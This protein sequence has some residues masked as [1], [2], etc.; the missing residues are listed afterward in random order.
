MPRLRVEFC[1]LGGGR[2][3][4][5]G[6]VDLPAGEPLASVTLDVT[7]TATPA[8][9]RPAVPAG[10]GTV[11][12]RLLAVDSAVYVDIAASPDPTTEPR[13]LL[14]PG[15]PYDLH[16]LPGQAVA[17]I[18]AADVPVHGDSAAI[19]PTDRSGTVGTGGAAQ[20][21]CPANA[22]RRFLLVANPDET[23]AFWFSTAGAAA[24]GAGSIQV[25]PGGAF[26]FDKV[27]PAGAVSIFGP[28]AGQPFTVTEA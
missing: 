15:R 14:V 19:S 6:Q 7:P 27:V 16:A 28:S 26:V 25:G 18:L 10:A 20:Q 17:A 23:R 8:E 9:S 22:F 12:V 24:Q 3:R 2:G 5:G 4:L 13:M 1:S 21:A 11:F